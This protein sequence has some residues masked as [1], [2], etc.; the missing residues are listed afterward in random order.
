MKKSFIVLMGVLF[1]GLGNAFAISY[2][3]CVIKSLMGFQREMKKSFA[4]NTTDPAHYARLA[5]QYAKKVGACNAE[6]LSGVFNETLRG[7]C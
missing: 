6:F 5:A 3:D 1:L 7:G 4:S 2:D